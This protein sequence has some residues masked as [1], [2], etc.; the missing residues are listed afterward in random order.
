MF[1]SISSL[2]RPILNSA[3]KRPLRLHPAICIVVEAK[4]PSI[5]ASCQCLFRGAT[6]PPWIQ[7][8]QYKLVVVIVDHSKR[9]GVRVR[10]R[11]CTTCTCHFVITQGGG[12]RV[13]K[14]TVAPSFVYPAHHPLAVLVAHHAS[15]QLNKALSMQYL[16]RWWTCLYTF[17][18]GLTFHR[19]P[20]S[21]DA[22]PACTLSLEVWV[23][24]TSGGRCIFCTGNEFWFEFERFSNRILQLG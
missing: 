17:F 5:R 20:T 3:R 19:P 8:A 10:E 7:H 14:V 24:S 4:D 1:C 18:R 16:G 2:S 21:W 22:G 9:E 13:T 23:F 15:K 12:D 11:S 6:W